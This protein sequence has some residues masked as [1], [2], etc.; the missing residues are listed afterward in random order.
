MKD[1]SNKTNGKEQKIKN[2]TEK[3]QEAPITDKDATKGSHLKSINKDVNTVST[4]QKLTKSNNPNN[5]SSKFNSSL[6]IPVFN[7]IV[8]KVSE[9][10]KNDN[11]TA[12]ANV[13]N[14]NDLPPITN[15]ING[16]IST[17]NDTLS[18][19]LK[20]NTSNGNINHLKTLS[21]KTYE[22]LFKLNKELNVYV[23]YNTHSS[24]GYLKT[25]TS[26]PSYF[27]INKTN[28]PGRNAH[29][30]YHYTI[31]TSNNFSQYNNTNT[32]Y[33][34]NNVTFFT[35]NKNHKNSN[36]LS[37]FRNS[38][39][40][41]KGYNNPQ[42][43]F[44]YIKKRKL[45]QTSEDEFEL[46]SIDQYNTLVSETMANYRTES[47]PIDPQSSNS[48]IALNKTGME[49]T[50]NNLNVTYGENS[51]IKIEVKDRDYKNPQDCINIL[52]TN[53]KIYDDI[54]TSLINIQK[55]YYDKTIF[56]IEKFHEFKKKMCKV[57]VCNMLP[58]TQDFLS[59]FRAK[60]LQQESALNTLINNAT[61]NVNSNLKSE[62]NT[63][64]NNNL[65]LNSNRGENKEINKEERSL[66]S[67]E[68]QRI[69]D[70]QKEKERQRER[71]YE[72]RKNKKKRDE[73]RL[74]NK[75]IRSDEM[76]LYAFYKYSSKNFPEGREQF[77]FD[78]NLMD[79]VMFGGIVTNKNNNV[80]TLD[81]SII[82]F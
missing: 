73:V 66:E 46:I 67:R 39:N 29:S 5:D 56:G 76:E 82:K 10:G 19:F 30:T 20:T 24:L 44:K 71:E 60:D 59:I 6:N 41:S 52:N 80:W 70:K 62:D 28:S 38:I 81:P 2:T 68:K 58:K 48:N 8:N 9:S 65:N 63:N 45:L 79:L 33:T 36:S 75:I 40:T 34:S 11:I 4:L 42:K 43:N 3:L 27:K 35:N 32:E 37:H 51:L 17:N 77:A 25:S 26:R 12:N 14:H 23:N 21:Q 50:L 22:N 61:I 53:R 74:K 78:S 1:D 16:N 18:K 31:N 49:K 57:R 7:G 54:S 13:S 55:M 15:S 72:K 64:N 47:L 69:I